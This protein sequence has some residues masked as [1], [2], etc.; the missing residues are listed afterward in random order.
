VP[1][2]K[3]YVAFKGRLWKV[4]EAFRGERVA[5]RPMEM[6]ADFAANAV[7]TRDTTDLYEVGRIRV[8]FAIHLDAL[9]SRASSSEGRDSIDDV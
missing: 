9:P 1:A 8:R 4:P 3:D 7:R 2:T 5:I 6:D